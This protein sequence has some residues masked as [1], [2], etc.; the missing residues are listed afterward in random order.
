M[1]SI[2]RLRQGLAWRVPSLRLGA[3]PLR[4]QARLK[5]TA[6][7]TEAA[8]ET[9][10]FARRLMASYEAQLEARPVITK[11][12]TSGAL[13]G[14]GDWVA[15]TVER[16][17]SSEPQPLDGSR[18]MR[19]VAFGGL[20]YPLPAHFHYNFL[21]WLVVVRWGMATSRVPWVKMFIEQFVYWSYLSNAYYHGVLGAL[22][23]M[24]VAQVYDRIESTLWDT[25]KAQWAFCAPPPAREPERVRPPRSPLKTRLA[26]DVP[27]AA[28]PRRDPGAADQLQVHAGAPPAQLC[29]RGLALLD[30]LPLARLPTRQN[31]KG[32]GLMRRLAWRFWAASSAPRGC[33]QL[34]ASRGWPLS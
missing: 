29:A 34:R 1:S 26:A 14:L 28:R 31:R 27:C 5:G 11:S 32:R 2:L 25:L 18:W 22:Q 12:L 17:N 9:P 20:F 24:S 19:A 6:A 21:E 15:Q 13:Y 4:T 3:S 10:S 23:G 8:T 30:H 7:A 16:R 33:V